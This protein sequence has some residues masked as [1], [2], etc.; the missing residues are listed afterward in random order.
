MYFKTSI[1]QSNKNIIGNIQKKA[2]ENIK[3]LIF[4]LIISAEMPITQS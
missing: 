4:K 2:P 3:C 1:F